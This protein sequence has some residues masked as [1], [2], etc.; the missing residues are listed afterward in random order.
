MSFVA[1]LVDD[2]EA[3]FVGQFEIAVHWWIV[4][5]AYT[6]EVVLFQYLHVAA[7]GCLVHHVSVFGMLHVGVD[8]VQLDW[9]AVE[10]EHLVAYFCL[11]ES[12]LA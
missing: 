11:L 2:V 8:G 9:L 6:V 7:Y 12:H 10:V 5:C 1:C 4:R 3:V